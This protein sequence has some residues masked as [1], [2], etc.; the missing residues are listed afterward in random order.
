MQSDNGTSLMTDLLRKGIVFRLSRKGEG[1]VVRWQF[2]Q[3]PF[4]VE[5]SSLGGTVEEA[6]KAVQA[7]QAHGLV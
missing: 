5:G 2:Q 4:E 7:Q 1:Y 6:V 3:Q